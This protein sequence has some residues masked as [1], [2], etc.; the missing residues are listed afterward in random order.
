MTN[1]L[2]ISLIFFFQCPAAHRDLH[3]F[4][5]RRSSDLRSPAP[6]AASARGPP[7]ACR[8]SARGPASRGSG[9]RPRTSATDRKSTRLNSSHVAISYA[10]FCL[11]KKKN[12]TNHE[13]H[14]DLTVSSRRA[15]V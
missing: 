1:I 12:G 2:L 5:T 4:P 6:G 13:L 8:S 9:S 3:S 14:H 7:T 15:S 11:K 10:V